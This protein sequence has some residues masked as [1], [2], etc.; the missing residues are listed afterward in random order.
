[1]TKTDGVAVDSPDKNAAATEP[2][3]P[4]PAVEEGELIEGDPGDLDGVLTCTL[5][6]AASE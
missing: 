2:A 1:M 3:D 4:E 5:G 6:Q